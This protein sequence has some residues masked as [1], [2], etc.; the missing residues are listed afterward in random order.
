M[1]PDRGPAIGVQWLLSGPCPN[2]GQRIGVE[3]ARTTKGSD[4]A[5]PEG[6]QAATTTWWVP[7][8]EQREGHSEHVPGFAVTEAGHRHGRPVE[9]HLERLDAG[10]VVLPD[11]P[12]GGRRRCRYGLSRGRR[13]RECADRRR[14][15]RQGENSGRRSHARHS[16]LTTTSGN[17][18]T[19]ISSVDGLMP[20]PTA[21]DLLPT[22]PPP[23][24]T[25]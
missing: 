9:S 19:R 23:P 1:P 4:V 18:K 6:L 16:S 21:G 12:A 8:K 11:D 10:A 7:G 20:R 3:T 14:Q 25:Y 13:R 17:G 22:S 2:L 24:G 5:Q 15:R